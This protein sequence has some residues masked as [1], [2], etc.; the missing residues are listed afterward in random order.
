M[1]FNI[2]MKN[3]Y[4]IWLIWNNETTSLSKIVVPESLECYPQEARKNVS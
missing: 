1:V 2:G 4:I 3:G